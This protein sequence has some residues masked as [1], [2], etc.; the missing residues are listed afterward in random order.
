MVILKDAKEE[1]VHTEAWQSDGEQM[2]NTRFLSPPHSFSNL[3][4]KGC[5]EKALK[6]SGKAA[7]DF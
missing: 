6:C 4:I 2:G 5:S 3:E 7:S 1:K